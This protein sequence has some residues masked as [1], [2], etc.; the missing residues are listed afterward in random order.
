MGIYNNSKSPLTSDILGSLLEK[1]YFI[2]C[3]TYRF[4]R[5]D[6]LPEKIYCSTII[7]DVTLEYLH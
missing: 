3:D 6:L 2:L 7:V 4:N 5:Q 1:Y